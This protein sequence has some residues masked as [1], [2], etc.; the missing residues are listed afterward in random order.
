MPDDTLGRE[1]GTMTGMDGGGLGDDGLHNGQDW[2][3][4]RACDL[5]LDALLTRDQGSNLDNATPSNSQSTPPIQLTFSGLLNIPSSPPPPSNELYQPESE[6]HSVDVT[7][8]FDAHFPASSTFNHFAH[9]ES[10][11]PTSAQSEYN[12]NSEYSLS[13]TDMDDDS[14][15]SDSI[16]QLHGRNDHLGV[17]LDALNMAVEGSASVQSYWIAQPQLAGDMQSSNS[18]TAMP[19]QR[20]TVAPDSVSPRDTVSSTGPIRGVRVGSQDPDRIERE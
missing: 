17:G 16:P 2:S 14:E 11:R 7:S 19:H 1:L 5:S 20:R 3:L 4:V 18:H 6:Q 8:Q 15:M 9:F 13:A 10:F 12:S